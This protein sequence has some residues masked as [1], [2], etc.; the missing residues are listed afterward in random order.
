M[1]ECLIY[2]VHAVHASL[3]H[4]KRQCLALWVREEKLN[5][6]LEALI[7]D[8]TAKRVP[9]H[10]ASNQA[11]NQKF[12]DIVHQGV[13]LITEPLPAYTEQDLPNLI[14]LSPAPCLL[15][16]DG[17]TDPHNL[18][19]CLRAADGAGAQMVILPKDKSA[20]TDSPIVHKVA[21]GA[22]ESIPC[23]Q[24]TNLVRTIKQ[25]QALG[26]WVYGAA[27]EATKSLWEMDFKGPTAII[28]GAEGAGLRRLTR[29]S[30]DELFSLPMQGQVSSLNVSVATG[31]CL[32][33]VMRQRL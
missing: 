9:I 19:A 22:V 12:G 11:L 10:F 3:N 17:I 18:G 25:L 20:S 14:Q 29:D 8:A 26:I 33:E 30:C 32:Y 13:I 24:V 5:P 31:I 21:S 16:L 28:M 15:L 7:A 23:I 27:G 6:R 2:G 1:T 4:P